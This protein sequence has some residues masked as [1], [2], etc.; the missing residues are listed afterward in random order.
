MVFSRRPYLAARDGDQVAGE[1]SKRFAVGK[2]RFVRHRAP[3]DDGGKARR[4]L[5][6]DAQW[7]EH[8]PVH[9]DRR[10]SCRPQFLIQR[11]RR[12][13]FD[14]IAP[15]SS[16]QLRRELAQLRKLTKAVKSPLV[17]VGPEV[18]P[19]GRQNPNDLFMTQRI[20]KRFKISKNLDGVDE[21]ERRVGCRQ[22]QHR[23][24]ANKIAADL[25]CGKPAH[26]G[27]RFDAGYYETLIEEARHV[28]TDAAP[29]IE[30]RRFVRQFRDAACPCE[31]DQMAA[32]SEGRTEDIVTAIFSKKSLGRFVVNFDGSPAV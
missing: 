23:T 28:R 15:P 22:L 14:V 24:V 6:K 30:A 20:V 31:I 32:V 19:A 1:W 7:R 11:R 21:I 17:D 2:P 8:R 10:K 27:A 26:R 9:P 25:P 18:D 4:K 12:F 13:E 29:D 5:V 16:G 3:R